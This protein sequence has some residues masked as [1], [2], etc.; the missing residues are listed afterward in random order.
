[1]K[2]YSGSLKDKMSDK[3]TNH[4]F[5]KVALNLFEGLIELRVN[6]IIHSDIKP[7]NIL[8]DQIDEDFK[9]FYSDFGMC[10]KLN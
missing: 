3:F 4:Q 10:M 6:N 8:I 5:L 7:A 1:M 9:C 2:K